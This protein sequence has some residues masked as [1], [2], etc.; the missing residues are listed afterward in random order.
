LQLQLTAVPNP[1]THYFSLRI[2]SSNNAAVELRLVD[3]VGRVVE[4]WQGVA[5]NTTITVGHTYRAGVYY[6]KVIQDGEQATLKLVKA[7]Q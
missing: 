5:A 2:S 4:A 7:L 3:A 1:A 6:A